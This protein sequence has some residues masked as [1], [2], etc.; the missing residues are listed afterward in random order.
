MKKNEKLTM[1][2]LSIVLVL[3]LAL[4]LLTACG[5]S[6]DN[7]NNG[8]NLP[9]TVNSGN[10]S[11]DNPDVDNDPTDNPNNG[12]PTNKPDSSNP[13]VG[14]WEE[15]D[16]VRFKKVYEFKSNNKYIL[17]TFYIGDGQ[18]EE[19]DDPEEGTY[20]IDGE[21]LLMTDTDGATNNGTFRIE[22]NKLFHTNSAG[23]EIIYIK[24]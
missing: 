21:K 12:D 2:G 10:N 9:T 15:T 11:T 3:L 5:G 7:D 19:D 20:K 18:M 24:K 22:G 6:K 23:E 14:V 13:L 16:P 1:R 17:K 4:S 8:T